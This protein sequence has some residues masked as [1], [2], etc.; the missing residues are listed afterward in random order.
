MKY[1]V[2]LICVFL[3]FKFNLYS[4]NNI[5]KTAPFTSIEYFDKENVKCIFDFDKYYKKAFLLYNIKTE[6]LAEVMYNGSNF[7]FGNKKI[8]IFPYYFSGQLVKEPGSDLNPKIKTLARRTIETSE[9]KDFGLTESDLPILIVYNEKNELCGFSKDVQSIANIDCGNEVSQ[10][11]LLRL[12]IMVENP[13]KTLT[14]YA[15]KDINFIKESNNDTIAKVVSNKFG[16]FN[17]E[18]TDVH[19]NYLISVNEKNKNLKFVILGTQTGKV[20]GKFKATDKGFVYRLLEAEL[21][22]LPDIAEDEDLEMKLTKINIGV[23]NNFIVTEN[24]YYELGKNNLS[25]NSKELLEKIKLILDKNKEYNLVVISHT[26][27]QG[28]DSKNLNLSQKRSQT[29]VEYLETLGIDKKRLTAEGK[30]EKEIRNRCV[31]GVECSDDEH[32]YNRRTEF[33]FSK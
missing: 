2:L 10:I 4:Q 3:I 18:I 28:D 32:E 16:D 21:S 22:T 5:P 20:V 12:K 24:L 27:S 25:Q 1:S 11:K 15:G 7:V 17:I 30:G 8:A 6:A 23:V 14:P 29:V 26:D 33:K 19:Q 13:D 9:F 31:N